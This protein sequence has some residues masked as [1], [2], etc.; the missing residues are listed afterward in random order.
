MFMQWWFM[1]MMPFSEE[2]YSATLIKDHAMCVN[3]VLHVNPILLV[4]VKWF[5][6]HVPWL[7]TLNLHQPLS[8]SYISVEG[9]LCDRWCIITVISLL[10]FID[11]WCLCIHHGWCFY[12]Y[13]GNVILML[14]VVLHVVHI[15]ASYDISWGRERYVH[16]TELSHGMRSFGS[17]RGVSGHVHN[18]FAGTISTILWWNRSIYKL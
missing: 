11:W 15:N 5:K 4:I 3:T 9:K 7:L 6:R 2:P 16:E 12:I 13:Y 10:S 18:P 17:M 14:C 1:S 8:I